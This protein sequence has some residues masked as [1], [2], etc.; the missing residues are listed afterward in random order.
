MSKDKES[1]TDYKRPNTEGFLPTKL[2]LICGDL[3][4]TR[5]SKDSTDNL[6]MNKMQH[7]RHFDPG[8]LLY[9]L[10]W[11]PKLAWCCASCQHLSINRRWC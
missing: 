11:P 1:Y 7:L 8:P 6:M 3:D 2:G 10:W 9:M 4:H 5:E